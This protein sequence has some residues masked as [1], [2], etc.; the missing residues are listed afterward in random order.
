MRW[1]V[2]SCV[3]TAAMLF[4]A[5]LAAAQTPPAATRLIPAESFFRNADIKD[6]KLSPSGRW[7][8]VETGLGSSRIRLVVFDTQVAGPSQQVANFDNADIRSFHWVNDD[9]LVFDVVDFERGGGDQRIAPGLFSVRRDGSELRELIKLDRQFIKGDRDKR[10]VGR[11]PLEWNHELL[12]IPDDNGDEVIVGEFR[13]DGR[14]DLQSI[15]AKRLDVTNG[16]ASTLSVGAPPNAVGWLF[17]PKGEPRVVETRKGGVVTIY[18]RAP[19]GDDWAELAHFDYLSWTFTPKYVDAQGHLFVTTDEGRGGTSVLK[20]FDFKAGRPEADALVSAA[21]FDFSGNLIIDRETGHALG[22]WTETDAATTVWFSP[23]MKAVQQAVDAKLPGRINWI[24]CRRCAQPESVVLVK[25]FSDQDPGKY[26]IYRPQGERWTLVGPARKD[27]DP[28]QM[29][30]LDFHRIKARDG[31]DLPLWITTPNAP[32]TSPRPAV[33]LV[34]GGPFLRGGHW[35]WNG[36]AQFLASRGYLVIEPEFRGSQGFGDAHFRAGWKQWGLAM[37]DDVA[38]AVL[39][40]IGQGWAD[41][42]RV[43]IAGASYGGY[44]TLMG[45]VRHP[46]LYRCGAAWVAVTDPRLLYDLDAVSDF[47]DEYKKYGLPALLGDRVKDAA[48]LAAVAPVEQA[49]RIKAPVLLAFGTLDR[50]VPIEHATRMRDAM[51]AAGQ[52]PDWIAN[53]GEGHGW[54]RL[55]NRVDFAQRLESFLARNLK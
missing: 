54:L 52:E 1:G 43:C 11:E 40:A 8:A 3:V 27:I 48:A 26:W 32:S 23:R 19:G 21:G 9:R 16:K 20:R 42:T 33:V 50:R 36:D 39:W 25:S 24:G 17:D 51:R 53:A 34:H 31:R 38:D 30:T 5:A 10:T 29:A 44:A 15:S 4:A 41:A 35:Q 49:A 12:A 28:R 55:E 2:R 45:L 18:W 6:A 46:D 13:F 7:L 47:P 22:V 37:Q 14:G